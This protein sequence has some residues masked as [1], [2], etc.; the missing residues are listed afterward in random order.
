MFGS[1]FDDFKHHGN[2]LERRSRLFKKG[3]LKY[4][5]LDLLKDKPSHGYELTTALEDRFHGL[6]SPSPGSVYPILQLLEDMGYVTS[7]LG[8]GKKVYTITD[9]GKKFL[10]DQKE[11]TQKIGERLRGWWGSEDR[12]RLQDVR[13]S[14][15]LAH[16]LF[17]LIGRV[18]SRG[19]GARMARINEILAKTIKEIEQ[20]E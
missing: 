19:D 3:D 5:I 8:E 2:P 13:A 14:M 9:S 10:E 15:G 20:I 17:H 4:V 12:G 6:Y 16:E 11:T 7:T 18:A 1:R